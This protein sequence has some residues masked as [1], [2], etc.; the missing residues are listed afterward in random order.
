MRHVLNTNIHD[1]QVTQGSHTKLKTKFTDFSLTMTE[2]RD[3]FFHM[4]QDGAR[5]YIITVT[6]YM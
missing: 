4:G 1:I 6:D 2:R 5:S 3:V